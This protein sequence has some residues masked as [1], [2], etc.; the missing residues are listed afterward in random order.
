VKSTLAHIYQVRHKK[1]T[2]MSWHA[3]LQ[4][5]GTI[6]VDSQGAVFDF[7]FTP[8]ALQVVFTPLTRRTFSKSHL[9]NLTSVV[10]SHYDTNVRRYP[11]RRAQ[12]IKPSFENVDQ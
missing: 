6:I 9:S 1:T 4:H 2:P 7:T 10:R 8:V 5:H 11:S 12:T 3:P